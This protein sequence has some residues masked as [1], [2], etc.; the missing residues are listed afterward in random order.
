MP[1]A[2]WSCNRAADW[3]LS[4]DQRAPTVLGMRAAA[5]EIRPD[6]IDTMMDLYCEWRTECKAVHAAYDRI[7]EVASGDRPAA[8][9]AYT[10]ALDREESACRAYATHVQAIMRHRPTDAGARLRCRQGDCR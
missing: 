4:G 1:P 9:A 10:A 5:I 6:L 3:T 2:L 8:F 7:D